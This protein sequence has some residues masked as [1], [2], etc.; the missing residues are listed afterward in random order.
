MKNKKIINFLVSLKRRNKGNIFKF[1]AYNR[2]I[3]GIEKYDQSLRSL[4]QL[5]ELVKKKAIGQ[6]IHDRIKEKFFTRK[7]NKKQL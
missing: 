7:L 3:K 5:E 4:K 2:A 1:L 6:R